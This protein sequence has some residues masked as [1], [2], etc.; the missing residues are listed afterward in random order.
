MLSKQ[1][2]IILSLTHTHSPGIGRRIRGYRAWL[3]P[4]EWIRGY[5]S[6]EWHGGCVSMVMWPLTTRAY[7]IKTEMSQR[8]S[9]VRVYLVVCES[10]RERD[11]Q[12][13]NNPRLDISK[14]SQYDHL[15]VELLHFFSTVFSFFLDLTRRRRRLVKQ[16]LV[17]VYKCFSLTPSP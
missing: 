6:W 7:S 15:I 11:S 13:K 5:R 1:G 2:L 14:N 17:F 4:W 10:E 8:S 16:A 3:L 12:P 9:C